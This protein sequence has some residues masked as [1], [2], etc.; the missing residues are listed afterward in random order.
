MYESYKNYCKNNEKISNK[1]KNQ[2]YFFLEMFL[3]IIYFLNKFV[4]FFFSSNINIIYIAGSI[5][6]IIDYG[7]EKN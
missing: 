1:L 2:F 7:F 3:F 6:K 5:I 4:S